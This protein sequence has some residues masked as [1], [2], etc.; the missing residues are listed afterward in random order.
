MYNLIIHSLVIQI[1]RVDMV[2]GT[3]QK[4]GL[5]FT[6]ECFQLL[7]YKGTPTMQWM[8]LEEWLAECRVPPWSLYLSFW[9]IFGDINL[10]LT[11]ECDIY[12]TEYEHIR[13]AVAKVI[14][15]RSL[16]FQFPNTVEPP[17]TDSPYY[18]NLHNAD[19]SPRS[20][21]IPYTI[22]YVLRKPPY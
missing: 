20:R 5:V 17:K 14:G 6:H 19:K 16:V 21:I 7:G 13:G 15:Q 12:L 2:G 9:C 11:I 4:N 1:T 10:V 8:R 3:R 22:V 18:R